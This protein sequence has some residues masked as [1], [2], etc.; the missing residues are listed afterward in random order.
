MEIVG[1]AGNYMEE[2]VQALAIAVFK[3]EKSDEGFLKEL[4]DA[5]GGIIRSVI[6]SEELKGK[7]GETAY[8]HLGGGGSIKA[9][10]LLLLGVGERND[11]KTPQISQFAGTAVRSLRAKNIKSIAVLPRLEGDVEKVAS[12][13]AEGAAIAL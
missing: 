12:A 13:A 10:R 7:E 2:D 4:D 3:D 1:S 5:T 8:L 6:E 11:F 9:K